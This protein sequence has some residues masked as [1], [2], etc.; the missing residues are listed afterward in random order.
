MAATTV[1]ILD[2]EFSPGAITSAK[3][4]L[5]LAVILRIARLESGRYHA[6]KRASRVVCGL[7]DRSSCPHT[8]WLYIN[9][10]DSIARLRILLASFIEQYNTQMP[11]PVHILRSVL[12]VRS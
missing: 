3:P 5:R 11:H 7:D 10:L 6:W 12:T 2:I 4:F 9:S 1:D 8:K